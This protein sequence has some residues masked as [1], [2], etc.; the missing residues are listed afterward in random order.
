MSEF[1][2]NSLLEQARNVQEKLANAQAQLA[3]KTV[4]GQSGGGMVTVTANGQQQIVSVK[5]EPQCVDPRDIKMLE[6]LITAATNQALREARGLAERE[7]GAAA[8]M[9]GIPGLFGGL[10]G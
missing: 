1:D 7:L 2:L 8:G 4:T 9:P 3:N 6:D 10:S 5:L